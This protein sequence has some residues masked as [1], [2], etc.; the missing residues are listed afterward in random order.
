M[1][2]NMNTIFRGSKQRRLLRGMN[3]KIFEYSIVFRC[4]NYVGKVNKTCVSWANVFY[5]MN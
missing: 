3:S 1:L 2:L 5:N 4:I